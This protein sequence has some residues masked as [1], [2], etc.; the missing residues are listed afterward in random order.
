MQRFQIKKNPKGLSHYLSSQAA[1]QNVIY[2]TKKQG[3]FIMPTGVFPSN[4]T[5]LF[6]NGRFEQLVE[7]AKK[8]F[9]YVIID[10]P[11]LGNV[12]DA[13]VVAKCCDASLLVIASD[14]SSKTMVRG[15]INQLKLSNPN[16]LGV[17]L[18]KVDMKASGYYGKKY[19]NYY[20]KSYDGYYGQSY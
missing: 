3:L 20:G 8:I 13:A 4:P 19:G 15:V 1:L 12:I 11:P 2:M 14:V 17:V 9:D 16:F 10:T 7:G 5:E 18:N 6:G